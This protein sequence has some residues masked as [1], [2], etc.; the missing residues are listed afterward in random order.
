MP[1]ARQ[2]YQQQRRRRPC[3]ELVDHA[4]AALAGDA[5]VQERS[6]QR[7]ALEQVALQQQAHLAE[8]GEHQCLLFGV[9]AGR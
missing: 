4:V 3:L 2:R 6:R 5:A 1:P 9:D 8:L 7:E